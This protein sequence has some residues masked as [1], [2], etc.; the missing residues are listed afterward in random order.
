[1]IYIKEAIKLQRYRN[2]IRGVRLE[3]VYKNREGSKQAQWIFNF[4]LL[5]SHN[6]NI[7]GIF[8]LFPLS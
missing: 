3:E 8:I 4:K 6:L 1:M 7:D 5:P 2:I